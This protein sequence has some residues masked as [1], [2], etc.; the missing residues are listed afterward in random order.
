M[1][2]KKAWF[3]QECR[4]QMKWDKFGFFKCPECGVEVW[5]PERDP[6]KEAKEVAEEL[7]D[8][9]I[10]VNRKGGGGSKGRSSKKQLMGKKST[11][12][13]YEEMLK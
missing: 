6:D 8:V 5:I 10:P 7:S 11:K 9:I 4:V 2:D 12:Q 13:L 1:T 3:C